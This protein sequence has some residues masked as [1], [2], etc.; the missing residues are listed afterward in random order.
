MLV[1]D[2]LVGVGDGESRSAV[3]RL[4]SNLPIAV[5][6]SAMRVSGVDEA[7]LLAPSKT[8][9]RVLPSPEPIEWIL[10]QINL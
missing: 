4:Y 9:Q 3:A 1:F 8:L 7:M 2:V 5:S 6:I 10:D